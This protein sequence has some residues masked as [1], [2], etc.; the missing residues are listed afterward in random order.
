MESHAA[1]ALIESQAIEGWCPAEQGDALF[2]LVSRLRAG[3][4]VV[5]LGSYKGLSTAWMGL[6]SDGGKTLRLVSVDLHDPTYTERKGGSG[7]S[8]AENMHALGIQVDMIAGDT[9]DIASKAL[10][11]GIA[12]WTVSL[13]YVDACHEYDSVKADFLSWRPLM[14]DEAFVVFDDYTEDHPGVVKFVDEMVNFQVIAAGEK[15][16]HAY[17]SRLTCRT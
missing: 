6:A 11:Y 3:S 13:L 14:E 4:T 16:G 9:I 12:P 17:F 10:D 15:I 7:T 5:E 8:L 2:K 1:R